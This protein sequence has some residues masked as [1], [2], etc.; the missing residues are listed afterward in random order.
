MV[1]WLAYWK[2]TVY[3]SFVDVEIFFYPTFYICFL[4]AVLLAVMISNPFY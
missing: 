1:T 3:Y 2:L 4:S